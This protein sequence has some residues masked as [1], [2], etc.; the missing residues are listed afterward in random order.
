[1]DC[2]LQPPLESLPSIK[3]F[4][5]CESIHSISI[6]TPRSHDTNSNWSSKCSIPLTHLG[7]QRSLHRHTIRCD[8]GLSLNIPKSTYFYD[9]PATLEFFGTTLHESGLC[10]RR[11]R[12]LSCKCDVVRAN[13]THSHSLFY[14]YTQKREGQERD[15]WDSGTPEI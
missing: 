5:E 12:P 11:L 4:M 8:V 7:P 15:A 1:M 13:S 10:H 2:R 9:T 14:T 3:Y 6:L